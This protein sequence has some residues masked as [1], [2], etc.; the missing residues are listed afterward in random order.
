[1]P[2]TDRKAVDVHKMT[3]RGRTWC[4]RFIIPKDKDRWTDVGV[5]TGA[6][7]G[8]RR[9]VVKTLGAGDHK[10]ARKRRDTV[11]SA[12]RQDLDHRLNY[13]RFEAAGRRR[14]RGVG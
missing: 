7:T 4:V 2:P 14:G 6:A 3:L 5:A 12:I 8:R 1:M 11:L 10:E 9:D 13:S